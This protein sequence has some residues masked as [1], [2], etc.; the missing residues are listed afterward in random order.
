MSAELA[1]FGGACLVV[2]VGLWAY[3]VALQKRVD[4][5]EEDSASGTQDSAPTAEL[6]PETQNPLYGSN[7]TTLR[8][9]RT[10]SIRS[11]RAA[12]GPSRTMFK[13]VMFVAVDCIKPATMRKAF[14]TSNPE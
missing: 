7:P 8:A 5:L 2:W 1:A 3:I 6:N 13:R 11:I 9:I 10:A 14:I 4:R 12:E